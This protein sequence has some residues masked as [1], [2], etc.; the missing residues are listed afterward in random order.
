[1][2]EHLSIQEL[3]INV[4][5]LLRNTPSF[6]HQHYQKNGKLEKKKGRMDIKMNSE[7][8]FELH[9][10]DNKKWVRYK[11]WSVDSPTT[12]IIGHIEPEEHDGELYLALG[13][14]VVN[15]KQLLLAMDRGEG[16]YTERRFQ[17]GP[18]GRRIKT[19][20]YLTFPPI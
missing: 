13:N 20:C 14:L 9:G 4:A 6:S 11:N 5:E 10:W 18:A 3:K 1:M 2:V 15:V 16:V 12:E 19:L 8:Q 17:C 7:F